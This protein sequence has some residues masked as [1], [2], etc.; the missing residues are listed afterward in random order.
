MKIS[1]FG[2][3]YVGCV[4]MGCLAQSGHNIIG[5][6]VSISKVTQINNGEA[7][8]IENKIDELIFEGVKK[9]L[10]KATTDTR[11]AV[12]NS[13]ITFITV[14]TPNG[15][16]GHLNLES[17]FRVARSIGVA[18][19]EK[20]GFHTIIIRSTVIPGTNEKISKIIEAESY[21]V[22]GKDFA[23][24][25]NPEFLR[26]GS[27]VNDFFNPEITVIGTESDRAFEIVKNLYTDVN[28]ELYRVS[29]RVAEM[30]KYV[31]NSFHALKIVFANEVGNICKAL[32]VDS[33]ELMEIFCKD[34]KLN[35][36]SYYL[37]PGFAYGGSCLPKDLK[38]LNTLAHD[39][40]IEVPV[41]SSVERSNS[42]QIELVMN[43]IM[44]LSKKN[45]GILGLSFKKGTDDLR[46]SPSVEIA[47]RLLGKGFWVN[48]YDKYIH[49]AKLTGTNLFEINKRIPRIADY[50]SDNLDEVITKSD[51]ILVTYNEPEFLQ[52]LDQYPDKEFIDVVRIRK[53]LKSKGN[54]YGLSW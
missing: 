33:H 40:Y 14:G 7:T 24:V 8:I 21:K 50:I 23:V 37:R 13:E 35:I 2:L 54:Y 53:E 28:T 34:K 17:V 1:F 32:N 30:I 16:Y 15:T 11:D 4:G 19:K 25:S 12:L 29:I 41:L 43:K 47:E 46:N 45:I 48:I 27:A 6:D 42:Y 36:S 22:N 26:E 38:A 39:C 10:I 49:L 31:N 3:G 20:N 52:M 5:T 9:G 44:E 51:V 18:L